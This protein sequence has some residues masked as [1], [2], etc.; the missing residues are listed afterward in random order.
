M[1]GLD[2]STIL[3]EPELPDA[4][5]LLAAGRLCAETINTV[6]CPFLTTY[7]VESEAAYKRLRM[8]EGALMFHAQFGF[9]NFDKSR[10][11]FAEIYEKLAAAGYRVDRYGICLDWSMGYPASARENMPRGTGMILEKPEDFRTLTQGAPVAPHFGDF[12]IGTPASLENTLAAL[13]AGSTSIGN[14]GQYFTF[15]MP[16]WRDDIGTTA[17]TVKAIALCA[18]APV[19]ILIHSNLDDGFAALFCDMACAIGAVLIERYIV[20]ELMGGK[21][22]HCYGHVYSDP[23]TRLAFQRALSRVSDTPGTMIYGNTTSFVANE[24]ENYANLAN[25]LTVDAVAQYDLPTGHGLNPVPVTEALRIPDI[26]EI[27]DAHLFANRLASRLSGFEALFDLRAADQIATRLV[28]GGKKFEQRVFGGLQEAGIDTSDPFEMLLSIRRIGAR[29]LEEL[30]GPGETT[31]GALRRRTPVVRATT[32]AAL[33]AQGI[34][35]V[36]TLSTGECDAIRRAGFRACVTSTDVH[37]YG[38]ILVETVLEQ[39]GVELIDAGVSA[40]P[41]KVAERSTTA[42]FVAVS[43]Y[44]GVALEYVR[45]LLDEMKRVGSEIPVFIGGKLNRVPDEG[46]T[47]MPVDVTGELHLLGLRVCARVEDMLTELVEMARGRSRD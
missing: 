38:K 32:V 31:P 24:V 43:T 34:G 7:G 13:T 14:L 44:S 3:P 36:E 6:S 12:V 26:D 10:R 41:E 25:Y 23:L 11:A 20:N 33:E 27:V 19:D 30:F 39:L 15:S 46:E 17:E 16:R 5:E 2:R 8:G 22:S 9:R 18:S 35:V 28:D 37:E 47:S 4:G 21:V 45:G 40:D 1:S 42:D 29:R